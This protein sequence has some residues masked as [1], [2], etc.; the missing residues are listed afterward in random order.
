MELCEVSVIQFLGIFFKK[1]LTWKDKM[2]SIKAVWSVLNW[3]PDQLQISYRTMSR[4][5]QSRTNAPYNDR[6][7]DYKIDR[8]RQFH[9]LF[10]DSSKGASLLLLLYLSPRRRA[11]TEFNCV[12]FVNAKSPDHVRSFLS[13]P[14]ARSLSS[15]CPL[16][17]L[18]RER[19]RDIS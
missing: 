14:L 2:A 17:D 10:C 5:G 16:M 18:E 12:S 11:F 6:Q 13:L 1:I 15:I 3:L 7:R 4:K 8:Q 9:E 19:K